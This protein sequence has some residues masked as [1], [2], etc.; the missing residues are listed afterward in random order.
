MPSFLVNPLRGVGDF[1]IIRGPRVETRG[2]LSKPRPSRGGAEKRIADEVGLL[3][4]SRP[5]PTYRMPGVLLDK[6]MVQA[7]TKGYAGEP[8]SATKKGIGQL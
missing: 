7:Y 6:G 5:E 2:Y 1:F 4:R 3:R 8:T